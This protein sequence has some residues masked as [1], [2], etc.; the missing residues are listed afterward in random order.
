[1]SHFPVGE[2][3][4]FSLVFPI[5]VWKVQEE[6]SAPKRHTGVGYNEER[7][8]FPPIQPSSLETSEPD[9]SISIGKTKWEP[10]SI[11]AL[12]LLPA[13]FS[14]LT[15]PLLG[16][17]HHLC[18][19]KEKLSGMMLTD[20]AVLL[21]WEVPLH[22]DNSSPELQALSSWSPLSPL[23]HPW[24]WSRLTF[25]TA[26]INRTGWKKR[27]ATSICNYD[28]GLCTSGVF[29]KRI[30]VHGTKSLQNHSYSAGQLTF[31]ALLGYK[32]LIFDD[33]LIFYMQPL[34]P[35]TLLAGVLYQRIN[36]T[37]KGFCSFIGS[38]WAPKDTSPLL[39]SLADCSCISAC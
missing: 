9:F 19:G 13:P 7:L 30:P 2:S 23:P 1:M 12:S 16:L 8:L 15:W 31:K 28:P 38:S 26:K 10:F 20:P 11:V 17:K 27:K 14:P 29:C 24:Q 4:S 25:F 33:W 37:I 22:K 3:S 21:F 6:S 36:E 39:W 18:C 32:I 34:T 35:F 5:E